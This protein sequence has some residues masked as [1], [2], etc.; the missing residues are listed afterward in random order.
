MKVEKEG[1]VFIP[2]CDLK[3]DDVFEDDLG[4]VFVKIMEIYIDGRGPAN[5]FCL[6]DNCF[7]KFENSK[8]VHRFSE[9]KLVAK[10]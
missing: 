3:L 9:V 1:F 10:N 4:R 2:F 6:S 8:T 5:A 7:A